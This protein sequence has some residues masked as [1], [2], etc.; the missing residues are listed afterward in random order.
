MLHPTPILKETPSQ[1]AGPYVHIGMTPNFC[2]ITGV[3]DTDLGK[4][5]LNGAIE[6]ERIDIVLRLIDGAGVPLSDGVVEIWQADASGNFLG[7][8][9]PDSNSAPA[10]TGWGRQPANETGELRFETIKP[11]RVPGPDG[12]LMAPHVALW[13]VARGINI[14]L[15]TRLYF[16]DEVE[17]NTGDFVLN[18]IMDK[19]RRE[20]LIARREDGPVPRYVLDIHLQGE[21]ETVFFDM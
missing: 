20:T 21:K 11:G 10:F 4:T 7:P 12:K 17:A 5:M 16:A 2:D 15:Q 9:T 6:G 19:R 3:I 1:T 8:T 13:I 18:K 14:G